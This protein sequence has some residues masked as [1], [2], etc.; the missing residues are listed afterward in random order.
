MDE[1]IN[2]NL[3]AKY[4]FGEAS[5]EERV[6]VEAW[7]VANPKGEEILQ[8]LRDV[9]ESTGERPSREWKTDALWERV[10]K[11]ILNEEK[12][13]KKGDRRQEKAAQSQTRQSRLRTAESSADSSSSTGRQHKYFSNY[14]AWRT[15]RTTAVVAIVGVVAF[16]IVQFQE[17]MIIGSSG[18]SDKVFTTQ[19]G[20]QA[21]IRL[22]DET[23]V[24]LNANSRLTLNSEFG[25]EAREV[26]L[27]GEAYF[28]VARDT[29]HPFLVHT[30][31]ATTEVLGTKFNVNSYSGSEGVQVVVAEGR[32][33][34]RPGVL[35]SLHFNQGG[36]SGQEVAPQ[37]GIVLERRQMGS[38]Y[39]SGERV[40]HSGVALERH[41]AWKEGLLVFQNAPFS[42]VK[43]KFERRY[44]LEVKLAD[45]SA[46]SGHLNARFSDHQSLN[47][48]LNITA[49]VFDM[50]YERNDKVVIFFPA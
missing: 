19:K 29:S 1:N 15:F 25:Q 41:L 13:R 2:W 42:E 45:S 6:V 17:G 18:Q 34:L 20:E 40:V 5:E 26:H 28:E 47:E 24:H 37:E 16:M 11:H 30:N 50:R 39:Q 4:L 27:R 48:V 10:Q 22:T 31:D 7:I 35:K 44:N 23:F 46:A 32:V 49:E 38:V 14:T 3:L 21:K 33:A 12:K 8:K 36:P 43:R 9:K